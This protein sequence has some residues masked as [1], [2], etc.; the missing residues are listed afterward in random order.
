MQLPT[1]RPVILYD[2]ICNLCN[3]SVR[4]ILKH[5]TREKFLFSSLQ[6][7][8]SKK[9]LLHLN[10][11]IIEMNSILLVENGQI[12]EKSD[13]VLK[14]ASGLRFPWNLTVSFRV[15]PRKVRDSIYDF[16]ARNRYRWF[17]KRDSCV[18]TVNTYE[19]RFI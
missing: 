16:V 5:D 11:K 7:D 8:A 2:G 1:D 14:I 10:Y 9:L 4:F 12:H 18:Y 3:S 13:A 15:L 17:G 6:S 19:N